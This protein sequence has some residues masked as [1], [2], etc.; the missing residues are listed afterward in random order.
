MRTAF[1][2]L[3]LLSA[4]RD[5]VNTGDD[6]DSAAP[7]PEAPIVTGVEAYCYLHDV[8]DQFYQWLFG[9]VV[10]DPQ[11]VET[12]E[13]FAD[14][15]IYRGGGVIEDLEGLIVVSDD[16]AMVGS[17]KETTYSISCGSASEYTFRFIAYDTDGHS[18]Y[19]ETAGEQR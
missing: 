8:G 7:D 12:L 5:K 11:G 4:C 10:D 2:A 17:F 9:G 16:G 3:A 15:E 18:G 13:G 6:S 1:A 19:A 14:L